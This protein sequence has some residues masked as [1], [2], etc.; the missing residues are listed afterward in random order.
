M[1]MKYNIT[2]DSFIG[3]K[4]SRSCCWYMNSIFV[5]VMT[6]ILLCGCRFKQSAEFCAYAQS[7]NNH[8]IHAVSDLSHSFSFY[9]DG[10]FGSQYMKGYPCLSNWGN[11]YE[12]DLE[13]AN[14]LILLDCDERL[15]YT[16]ADIRTIQAFVEKGGGVVIM[17]KHGSNPQNELAEKFGATFCGTTDEP[18]I[19]AGLAL[20][21]ITTQGSSSYLHFECPEEWEPIVRTD[22]G[23]SVLAVSQVGK[24]RILVASRSLAGS[25]PNASDSINV[26]LWKPLLQYI[27]SGKKVDPE[28]AFATKGWDDLGNKICKYGLNVN[29][30]DYMEPYAASMIDVTSRCMPFIEK[31]MGVPLSEGMGTSIMLLPTGGGGFSAG[32]LIAL[33]AWWGGFPEREDA[34]IEFITHESVHSWVLPYPEIWNEPIATYIGDLVMA[35]MG[36][37][38]ESA[39]LIASCIDRGRAADPTFSLYDINGKS[40]HQGVPDL[41]AD[42]VNDLHWGKS[43][44]IFEQLRKENPDF[45]ADYFRAKRKYAPAG[46]QKYDANNTVAV[47]S[48]AMKRNLFPW[49]RSIGFDVNEEESEIKLSL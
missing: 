36:H 46:L 26:T 48:I 10:R 29:Y 1:Q 7:S 38:E 31:R 37:P 32:D 4:R 33:A 8:I 30:S 12:Q 18:L 25:H 45:V 5:C 3:G 42:K 2:R 35:N 49:F 34:M 21:S 28:R 17:G 41:P 22:N 40:S 15:S 27:T 19:V 23:K 39:R 11:L 47:L 44:W 43:F 13:N 6:V 16:P 9:A 24:G 14:L 20:D